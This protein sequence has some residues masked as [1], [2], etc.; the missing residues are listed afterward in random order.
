MMEIDMETGESLGLAKATR[1]QPK[2]QQIKAPD[3]KFRISKE[4]KR[5][6][7]YI[8]KALDALS[9]AERDNLLNALNIDPAS[10]IPRTEAEVRKDC[11]TEDAALTLYR[12][13]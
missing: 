13:H 3:K 8:S 4:D 12:Y 7:Y 6:I 1:R 5:N 9:Q 2:K 11:P 10:L